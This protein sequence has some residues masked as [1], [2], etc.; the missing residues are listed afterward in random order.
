MWAVIAIGVVAIVVVLG[1]LAREGFFQRYSLCQ[2][3]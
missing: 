1:V 3:R 2:L